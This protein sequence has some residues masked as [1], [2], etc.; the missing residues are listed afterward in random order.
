M[1]IVPN[2]TNAQ[3]WDQFV[4]SHPEGRYCQLSGYRCIGRIYGY[5][6]HYIGFLR[7]QKLAGVL[8]LFEAKS[9][10]FGRRLVSSPFSEY[11][12]FLL[13]PDWTEDEFQEA[14]Q[15]VRALASRL[16]AR[17]VEFHGAQ[18]LPDERFRRF[19]T[20]SNHQHH[21]VLSLDHELDHLYKKVL[22]YQVRKAIQK[23]QRSNLVCEE[24]SDPDTLRKWF[25]PL[26]LHSM[27]RVGAPPHSIDYYVQLKESMG[28]AM[29]IHW[30]LLDGQPVAG[31][32]G[33]VCGRRV[34]I[35]HIVS[36]EAHWELRPNDLVH[37]DFI[38]WAHG[39]GI[40]WFDF[41]SVRYE[42]QRRFKEKWGCAIHG[43][44]YYYPASPDDKSQKTFDSSSGM[45]SRMSSLWSHYIPSGIAQRLG[46]LLRHHLIR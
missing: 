26:Y 7:N 42:G 12:G 44:A 23:A 9:I 43:H 21:A 5:R 11:G 38:Q 13:D 24:R 39:H 25:G 6:P 37:W 2:F 33:F 1:E 36:T 30:A 35:V 16:G 28:P 34:N 14:I 41:G 40:R 3:A 32:L 19:L 10:L 20:S 29:R 18:G 17:G 46:P 27:K 31:L 22:D 45:M 8:P 4:E 15:A